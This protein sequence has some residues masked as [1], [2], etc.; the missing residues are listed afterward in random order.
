MEK[1]DIGTERKFGTS[2]GG[3]TSAGL[4]GRGALGE[5]H[6]SPP[7]ARLGG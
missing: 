7:P 3:D 4:R 6:S 5:V 2:L 1:R